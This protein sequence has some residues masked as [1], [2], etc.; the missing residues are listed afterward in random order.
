M[1]SGISDKK[2]RKICSGKLNEKEE[3]WENFAESQGID[4]KLRK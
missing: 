1:V 4:R 2:M 3:S